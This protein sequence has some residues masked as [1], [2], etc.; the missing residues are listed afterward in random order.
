MVMLDVTSFHDSHPF[1]KDSF[2][3]HKACIRDTISDEFDL[4]S[5]LTPKAAKQYLKDAEEPE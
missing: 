5:A 2:F 4:V 1:P 3:A